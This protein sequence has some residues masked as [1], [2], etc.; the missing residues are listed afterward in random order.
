MGASVKRNPCVPALLAGVGATGSTT[1]NPEHVVV[2]V[3]RK[4]TKLAMV[5]TKARIS[6][7]EVKSAVQFW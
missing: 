1:S 4:T 7:P 5:L 2:F 6:L 3:C